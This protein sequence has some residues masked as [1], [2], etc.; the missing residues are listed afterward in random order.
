MDIALNKNMGHTS[1]MFKFKTY[2]ENSTI[3]NIKS[4]MILIGAVAPQVTIIKQIGQIRQIGQYPDSSSSATLIQAFVSWRLNSFNSLR[5][6]APK[7]QVE[8]YSTLK[9]CSQCGDE[10]QNK[11]DHVTHVLKDLHQLPIANRIDYKILLLTFKAL[12]NI[13]LTSIQG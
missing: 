3:S 4:P 11:F 6:G 2:W 9:W 10:K 8:S 12:H 5:Y 7:Q 13:A 1:Y